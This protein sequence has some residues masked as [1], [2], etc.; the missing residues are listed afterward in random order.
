MRLVVVTAAPCTLSNLPFANPGSC[1]VLPA[2]K[3]KSRPNSWAARG[4]PAAWQRGDAQLQRARA[5]APLCVAARRYM[6]KS[7][8]KAVANV[9]DVIAPAIIVRGWR[10]RA[11]G[12]P[13]QMRRS[14]GTAMRRKQPRPPATARMEFLRSRLKL[15]ALRMRPSSCATPGLSGPAYKARS[16][17]TRSAHLSCP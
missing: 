7:V 17:H 3:I 10:G 12:R 2:V 6:G 11:G 14:P 1:L 8:L 13:G 9:N 4:G 5:P 15:S 16:Q